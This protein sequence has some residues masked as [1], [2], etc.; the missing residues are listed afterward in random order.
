MT[1]SFGRVSFNPEAISTTSFDTVYP[2]AA[3]YA[4]KRASC[5]SAFDLFSDDDTRLYNATCFVVATDVSITIVPVGSWRAPDIL[6]A[7]K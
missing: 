7:L 3:A 6:P 2:F 4:R 1:S 5:D